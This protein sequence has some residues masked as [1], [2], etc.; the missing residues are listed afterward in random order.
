MDQL[1]DMLRRMGSAPVPDALTRIDDAV[2]QGLA[3]RRAGRVQ[4]RA[5]GLVALVALVAGGAGG[6][7]PEGDGG[8]LAIAPPLDLAPSSLLATDA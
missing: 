5:L 4:W 6:W 3:A 1:D 7:L 2:M 8:L